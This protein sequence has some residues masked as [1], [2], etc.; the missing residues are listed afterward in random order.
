VIV[1]TYE[2]HYQLTRDDL[3]EASVFLSQNSG[4]IQKQ[5]RTIRMVILVIALLCL[6][7][8]AVQ[9]LTSSGGASWPWSVMFFAFFVA[10]FLFMSTTRRQQRKQSEKLVDAQKNIIA[11]SPGVVHMDDEGI[12]FR[13]AYV[14]HLL[15]WLAITR[16][17]RSPQHIL[18][19]LTQLS[20]EV[21]PVRAFASPEAA[22]AFYQ[23]A[24]RHCSTQAE[25][26]RCHYDLRGNTSGICPEC[27]TPTDAPTAR[28]APPTQPQ[29]HPGHMTKR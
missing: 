21:I 12:E 23:F 8:A 9:A 20:A 29:L 3:I 13:S 5:H 24:I 19:Y 15:K 14:L 2:V 18:V 11:L 27:G 16:V 25:C 6:V 28:N 17:S 22:E 7:I 1:E 4:F 26:P 10:A